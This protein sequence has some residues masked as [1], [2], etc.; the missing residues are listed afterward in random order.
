MTI[1]ITADLDRLR[2]LRAATEE[3]RDRTVN[4]IGDLGEVVGVLRD[5]QCDLI[6]AT[7]GTPPTYFSPART[8]YSG[9]DNG[10]DT[11]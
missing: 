8:A 6:V 2:K 10:Y 5:A 1:D 4:A 7:G 11:Q 3:T 9:E